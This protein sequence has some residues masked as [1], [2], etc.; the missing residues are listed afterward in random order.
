MPVRHRWKLL[1]RGTPVPGFGLSLGFAVAYLTVI[2]LVPLSAV[3]LHGFR[4]GWAPFQHAITSP[5]V[6]ASYRLTLGAALAAALFSSLLGLLVAWVLARY[7]FPA[8]R[9]LDALVDLPFAL[10][11]AVAGISL[12][13]LYAGNGWLGRHLE[14][15]GIHVAFTPLGIVLA[16]SFVGFPFV[17]RSVQP[18]LEDLDSAV[19]EAAASLGAGAWQRFR[20]VT[21]PTIMPALLTGTALAFARGAGEYGSVIFIA[22]NMPMKTEITALLIVTKLEE[23]DYTGATAIAGA[24]LALSFSIM[25][26]VNLMQLRVQR[27]EGNRQ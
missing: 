10:P 22:G 3:L 13:A 23:Y 16:M 7:S 2:V 26:L 4:Q 14:P 24:M 25:L 17:V 21:F 12:S 1:A 20:R 8:K 9:L 27:R 6:E 5:R 19:E 18:V 11:T 15:H